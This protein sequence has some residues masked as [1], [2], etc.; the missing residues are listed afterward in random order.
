MIPIT[1]SNS[2]FPSR[3]FARLFPSCSVLRKPLKTRKRGGVVV[4]SPIPPER[5]RAHI[6]APRLRLVPI[7]EKRKRRGGR[8]GTQFLSL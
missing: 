6:C 4:P 7:A 8:G 5:G 3:V 2:W 1:Q